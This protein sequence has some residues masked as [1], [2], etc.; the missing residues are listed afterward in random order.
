M[1]ACERARLGVLRVSLICFK[2]VVKFR[3]KQLKLNVRVRR[4]PGLRVTPDSGTQP[5]PGGSDN[6]KQEPEQTLPVGPGRLSA[7]R[8]MVRLAVTVALSSWVGASPSPSDGTAR[9][10]RRATVY[11]AGSIPSHGT[12]QAGLLALLP[13]KGDP[14]HSTRTCL[15]VDMRVKARTRTID[16]G[17]RRCPG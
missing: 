13:G 7:C 1:L 3:V 12:S 5:G 17:I 8:C 2:F 10:P 11:Q 4:R 6:P 15:P 9:G 14:R 16:R